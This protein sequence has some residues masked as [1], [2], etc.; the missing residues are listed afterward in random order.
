[1]F[2]RLTAHGAVAC[3]SPMVSLIFPSTKDKIRQYYDD[4]SKTRGSGVGKSVSTAH[5]ARRELEQIVKTESRKRQP[6]NYFN[7]D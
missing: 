1:M 5:I 6:N 2:N 3:R 4:S 7:L